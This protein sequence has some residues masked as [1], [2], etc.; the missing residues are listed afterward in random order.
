MS[1]MERTPIPNTTRLRDELRVE[2]RERHQRLCFTA[3]LVRARGDLAGAAVL[4]AKAAK[5]LADMNLS[6]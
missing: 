3:S 2:Q 4:E 1:V 6:I 5:V